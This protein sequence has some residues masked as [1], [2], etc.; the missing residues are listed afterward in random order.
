MAAIPPNAAIK[1]TGLVPTTSKNQELIDRVKRYENIPWCE[2]YERM[3][4]G[5]L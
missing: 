2:Q 1:P 3:I 5:M 4:S